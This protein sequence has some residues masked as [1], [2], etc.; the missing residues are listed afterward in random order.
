MSTDRRQPARPRR[1]VL[2]RRP[3][4]EDGVALVMAMAFL[5]L[6]SSLMLVM[7]HVYIGQLRPGAQARKDLSSV[8][9]AS[10]GLQAALSQLR[11]SLDE[12]GAGARWRL[13]C[14]AGAVDTTSFTDGVTTAP[15]PGAVL[16]AKAALLVG[17]PRFAVHVAYFPQGADP[18]DMPPSWLSA[19]ALPCPLASTPSFA[20]LQSYGTGDAVGGTTGPAGDRVQTA[21]YRFS[22]EG[23]NVAGGRL[24]TFG[25]DLC[26]DAGGAPEAGSLLTIEPCLA[27]GTP[28]QNW[29]Y[30][31]DLTL[32]YGG[33][34]SLNLCLTASSVRQ[35]QLR[36]CT[37]T[38][39]GPTGTR[40]SGTTYVYEPGQQDQLWSLD[41]VAHFAAAR[42]DGGV[43]S[44]CLQPST[45]S[46]GSALLLQPCQGSVS[47]WQA[48]DPDPSVGAGKAGGN[49][50]GRPGSPTNQLVNYAQFG[51]CL[52][53]TDTNVDREFMI[54]YP[55]KQAPD[56]A[57]L[58]WNQ[59]WTF[60]PIEGDVGTLRTHT[61]NT[62]YCLMAPDTGDKPV[63]RPCAPVAA[64]TPA[65]QRW[66]A[67]GDDPG[68]PARSFHL[69]NLARSTC[70]SISLTE[71]IYNVGIV[72]L[73][74][75]S[76][77]PRQ[78]WNAPPPPPSSGLDNIREGSTPP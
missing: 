74:P 42:P 47:D 39:S 62:D 19:N 78:R 32:F 51:R 44:T 5:G 64:D 11:S 26:V 34:P 36:P 53:V 59:V 24:R 35:P 20:F 10:S 60:V 31:S 2:G 1:L 63:V 49:T 18:T 76:G 71:L 67:T 66:R 46:A 50:T 33:D 14:V 12:Q 30:R 48:F 13:P 70:L 57:E 6:V 23:G 8:N 72:V 15:A 22:V 75:C 55:C 16:S 37:G 69:V 7:L 25:T 45:P 41:D 38:G 21:V 65:V 29:E 3:A 4:G 27:Q 17:K 68:D 43:D 28:R 58:T 73:E 9:A 54:A 56:S 77:S 40:T 61:N 52:D